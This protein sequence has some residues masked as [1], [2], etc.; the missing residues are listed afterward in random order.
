MLNLFLFFFYQEIK[1]DVVAI[2]YSAVCLGIIAAAAIIA[3]APFALSEI[4]AAL[5]VD[6]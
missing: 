1:G 3:D 5:S 6:A 4:V 2:P